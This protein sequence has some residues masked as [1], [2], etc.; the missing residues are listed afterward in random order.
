[1]KTAA[2]EV[3]KEQ[4]QAAADYRGGK[5]QSLMFL[6]GQLMRKTKGAASPAVSQEI[7]RELLEKKES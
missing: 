1:M 4:P 5:A 6:V 7:L 3:I 2:A